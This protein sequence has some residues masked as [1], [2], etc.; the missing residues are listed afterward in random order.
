MMI[1]HFSILAFALLFVFG[2]ADPV[3]VEDAD[4]PVAES[5]RFERPADD[6]KRLTLLSYLTATAGETGEFRILLKALEMTDLLGTL[7]GKR[8]VTLFAPSNEAFK[9][10]LRDLGAR[11]LADV[12]VELL[13]DVLL[14]HMVRGRRVAE[15]TL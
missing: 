2:C 7:E 10:L 5:A 15:H 6:F 11:D 8:P 4:T 12:P 3:S 1:K 9:M 13:E 14:Y